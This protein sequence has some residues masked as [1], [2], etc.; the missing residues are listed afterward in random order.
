V[1]TL[2]QDWPRPLR[3]TLRFRAVSMLAILLTSGCA[4]L[5]KRPPYP[6]PDRLVSVI[7]VA[8]AGEAPVLGTDF[9]ALR[10]ESKTLEPIV[11]YVFT[12]LILTD[13]GMSERIYS[14]QVTSDFFPALGVKPVLG[15]ALVPDDNKPDSAPV[16]V[17][18]HTLWQ[19][20]YGADPNLIG[21][22][23]TLEGEQYTVVGIMPPDVYFPKDCDAWTPLASDLQ[24]ASL[25]LGGKIEV[26]VFARLKPGV[27]LKQAQ[28]EIS[29]IT[30]KLESDAAGN[31]TGRN[32]NL[33]ALRGSRRQIDNVREIR[34]RRPV[35]PT[36][37]TGKEK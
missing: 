7:K 12:G 37:E 31:S 26:E 6:D 33:T 20:R 30:S 3:L 14:A 29:L 10:S 16:V 15:R 24:S 35:K 27:T 34:I 2:L 22:A 21:R 13:G 11:A 5:H 18:S 1:K 4:L 19:R 28:A 36:A 23:M 9:L 25:A 8:P 17:I 32:L